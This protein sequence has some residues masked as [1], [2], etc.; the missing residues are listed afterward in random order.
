MKPLLLLLAVLTALLPAC[1]D[2]GGEDVASGKVKEYAAELSPLNGS[3]VAGK[4]GFEEGE[5]SLAV[6]VS[7]RP[8]EDR[9]ILALSINGGAGTT[10]ARCP[11]G[12]ASAAE[13]RSAYGQVLVLVRPAPTI[14]RGEDRLRYDLLVPLSDGERRRLEPLEGRTLVISRNRGDRGRGVRPGRA[15]PLAC[16]RISAA[17]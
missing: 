15:L 4:A 1:G 3:G 17:E 7:A 8:F 11:D 2:D 9:Q 13:G 5:D 6:T 16:G 12:D 10:P 14:K